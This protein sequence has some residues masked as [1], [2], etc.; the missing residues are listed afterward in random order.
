MISLD[1]LIFQRLKS[2]GAMVE[3]ITGYPI[4]EQ[5]IGHSGRVTPRKY[6]N[7]K[8][9]KSFKLSNHKSIE[10]VIGKR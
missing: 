4:A 8:V 2:T 7:K 10:Q 3:A 9:E 6:Q 1:T 5:L